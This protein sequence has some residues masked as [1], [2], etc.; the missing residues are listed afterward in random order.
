MRPSTTRPAVLARRSQAAALWLTPVVL[1]L[2]A[3]GGGSAEAPAGNPAAAAQATLE[4][5][6]EVTGP[7]PADVSVEGTFPVTVIGANGSVT[8]SAPPQKIVS[9][10]PTATEMLFA[11]GAGEQVEAVDDNSDFPANAP[12]T[13]LSAF[14]PNAEAVAGYTPDLVIV[15]NDANGLLASLKKLK[16][17]TV[18]MPAATN[19]DQSYAQITALGQAT[20]HEADAE[21]VIAETKARIAKAVASAPASVKGKKV[22]HELDQTFYSATS[23]TFVGSIYS[24]FGLT[25]IA[26]RAKD[27]ASSGGYPKLSA[28][29]VVTSAPDLIVLA[30]TKCCQQSAAAVAKRPGFATVPAV[31]AGKVVGTDDDIASRW[32]PRTA[33]FAESI[34][35]A[36]QS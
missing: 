30:D 34:A 12:T 33:D 8:L 22:Y 28:E 29:Y 35:K 24:M 13:K 4:S 14:Q 15:S 6:P 3:C 10:S 1:V 20:G 7:L 32:G 11:I 23:T 21:K 17:P 9:M 26:D 19:L 36:L 25:N 5:I 18:V 31:K 2:A 16:V 27:A